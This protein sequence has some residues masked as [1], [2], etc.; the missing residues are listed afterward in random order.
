MGGASIYALVV[1][2]DFLKVFDGNGNRTTGDNLTTI[3]ITTIVVGAFVVFVTFLGCCGAFNE[4]KCMLTVYSV[5][6]GCLFIA[7]LSGFII[8]LVL[9]G[10]EIEQPLKE[11]MQ[12]YY[13]N[14]GIHRAWDSLQKTLGCCG[15]RTNKTTCNSW[16]NIPPKFSVPKSCG[17]DCTN[18]FN[19]TGCLDLWNK[20]RDKY[21]PII[22]GGGMG[23]FL[24]MILNVIFA[25]K[26][27]FQLW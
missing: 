6:V 11:S 27:V 16:K 7:L 15:I 19:L 4:N 8:A 13:D 3:L 2:A 22:I 24:L 23:V 1:S 12:K 18:N 10:S 5:I 25:S 14:K 17:E 9:D 26:L 21:K 20:T